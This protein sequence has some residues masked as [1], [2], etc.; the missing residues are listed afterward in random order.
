MAD[1]AR[2]PIFIFTVSAAAL[3]AAVFVRLGL[4]PIVAMSFPFLTLFGAIAVAEWVG[5]KWP[6]IGV[7]AVGYVVASYLFVEPRGG[8]HLDLP[9]NQISFLL[10]SGTAA[11]LIGIGEYTWRARDASR[12]AS[13]LA[14]QQTNLLLLTLGSIGDG[15]VTTN[16]QGRVS[17]MNPVAAA[18]AGWDA[19]EAIGKPLPSVL[20]I[21]DATTREPVAN[22]V[23]VAMREGCASAPADPT[24]LIARD[25][26]ERQVEMNVA[27]IK[28]KEAAH[29]A[30]PK[31]A[32]GAA[33]KAISIGAVLV[34]RDVTD[35]Q[36]AE[37]SVR[38]NEERLRLAQSIARIGMF[39]L[40]LPSGTVHAS[41]ALAA[42]YGQEPVEREASS[43][44]WH[45]L[46]HPEDRDEVARKTIESLVTGSFEHEFRVVWPDGSVHWMAGRASPLPD[47]RGNV[48]R[49]LGINI[50]IT[51]QKNA[52]EALKEADR[53]KDQFLATLA[54]ELRNPLA[55]VRNA[56]DIMKVA[57]GRPD[58]AEF[59]E[60]ARGMMERQVAHLVR[61]IDDLLDVS[62]ITRN[63]LDLRKERIE[64]VTVI[65]QA[66]ETSRPLFDEAGQKLGV[67]VPAEPIFLDGDAVRL[68]QV[69][70][71]LLTNASKY[72]E[73]GGR[74]DLDARCE[75]GAVIVRVRDTGVGIPPDKLPR[76]FDMFT[77]IDRSLSRSQGGLGIG[78]ALVKTLVELHG[79]TVSASSGGL[80]RGSEFSVRLPLAVGEKIAKEEPMDEGTMKSARRILVVDDNEDA[81]MTLAMLLQLKGSDTRMAHDGVDAVE[82][83][84]SFRP[85]VI[86]L[87]IGLPK[88]DGYDACRAIREQPWGTGIK[89]IALTG[90][91]QEEDRRKSLE[92][93]FDMH[94]VKPVAPSALMKMLADG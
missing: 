27:P 49:M 34:F 44:E 90:W 2:S 22:P 82:Q 92:A 94:L 26:R 61:L 30:A 67:H 91:G 41:A 80:G 56:L 15:V 89:M 77:Q 73:R 31:A 79:G 10:Y 54:H 86:L 63:R 55:P 4:D 83:A 39:E 29:E 24:L 32:Y 42:M 8:L 17:Y 88:M 59:I 7:A 11:I 48:T 46:V 76:V 1:K 6:A 87:D 68:A 64:L 70:G 47:E 53:N 14:E 37:E 5:G 66:I 75:N 40:D 35:R 23:D 72:T 65:E 33:P 78:L 52:E 74:I 57:A 13:D 28:L 38:K 20:R 51:E 62:R 81:A 50:D 21:V 45:A 19:A 3:V 60:N 93:G 9:A 69:F 25:G 36:R 85:D 43:A 16:A 84:A 12:Q 71:N 58:A 18:F